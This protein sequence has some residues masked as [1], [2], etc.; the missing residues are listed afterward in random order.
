MFLFY[1]LPVFLFLLQGF[2]FCRVQRVL[3]RLLWCLC[4]LMRLLW[5]QMMRLLFEQL[6][7]RAINEEGISIQK[8]VE[9]LQIPYADVEKGCGLVEV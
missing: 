9:L 7:F 1:L 6:V 5:Q 3:R 2:L 8:G 4:L